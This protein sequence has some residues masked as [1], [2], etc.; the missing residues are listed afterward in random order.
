MSA[1]TGC[2][3]SCRHFRPDEDGEPWGVCEAA[4]DDG[5]AFFLFHVDG[6]FLVVHEDHGC[7]AWAGE[8]G[9]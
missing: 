2:C 7:A 1:T 6:G 4:A 9:E 5:E 8:D 3:G